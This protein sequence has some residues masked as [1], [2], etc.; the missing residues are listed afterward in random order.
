MFGGSIRIVTDTPTPVRHAL[1]HQRG[2]EIDG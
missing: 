1:A 2:L